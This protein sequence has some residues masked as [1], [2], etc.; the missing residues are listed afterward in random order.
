MVARYP[1]YYLCSVQFLYINVIYC[2]CFNKQSI[3][4][5]SL[6]QQQHLKNIVLTRCSP[7][8]NRKSFGFQPTRA[9]RNG[10]MSNSEE[11]FL[12]NTIGRFTEKVRMKK[13][14]SFRS[15]KI[16]ALDKLCIAIQLQVFFSTSGI[17]LVIFTHKMSRFKSITKILSYKFHFQI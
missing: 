8:N 9:Y 11:L 13:K 7:N 10:K 16:L 1:Q 3:N 4:R 17:Y 12:I 2:N 14:T 15:S 5:H 6:H